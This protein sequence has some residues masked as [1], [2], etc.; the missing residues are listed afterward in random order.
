[1]QSIAKSTDEKSQPGNKGQPK[2]VDNG[3]VSS[4]SKPTEEAPE[5]CDEASDHVK[6]QSWAQVISKSAK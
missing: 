2:K 5:T 6:F 3:L 4:G 1:M